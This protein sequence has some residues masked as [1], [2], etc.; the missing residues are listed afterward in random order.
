[1]PQTLLTQRNLKQKEVVVSSHSPPHPPAKTE[2]VNTFIFFEN[3]DSLK[4]S[5]LLKV[6]VFIEAVRSGRNYQNGKGT[7][8]SK[9]LTFVTDAFDNL[10]YDLRSVTG[11]KVTGK[12]HAS[13]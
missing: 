13:V 10:H 2:T 11:I 7:L 1:M 6:F 12:L 3:R 9:H 8:N 5:L 4:I